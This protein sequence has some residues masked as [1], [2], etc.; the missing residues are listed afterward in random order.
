MGRETL[1][2]KNEY[3]QPGVYETNFSGDDLPS[4]IYFYTLESAGKRIVKKMVLLK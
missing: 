2:L 4:G 1:L 3:H